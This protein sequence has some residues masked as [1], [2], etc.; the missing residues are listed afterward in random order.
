[1]TE[2]KRKGLPGSVGEGRYGPG[3]RPIRAIGLR[4]VNRIIAAERDRGTFVP[5]DFGPLDPVIDARKLLPRCA[6]GSEARMAL[7]R[8][9]AVDGSLRRRHQVQ[10]PGC[11]R[12]SG[13]T[14]HEWAAVV[15]WCRMVYS[16]SHAIESFPFFNLT[17]LSLAEAGE[18]VSLIRRELELR[19][20]QAKK[21]RASGVPT[22]R[23]YAERIEAYLGWTIAAASLLKQHRKA[24]QALVEQ[25]GSSHSK[26]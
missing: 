15:D 13:A 22:G 25:T 7:I 4:E 23:A 21:Q 19:K 14:T 10:C 5:S 12:T 17:G 18:R 9:N 11:G 1:M 20:Q 3:G 24:H 26:E 16:G 8:T 6:C 2:D